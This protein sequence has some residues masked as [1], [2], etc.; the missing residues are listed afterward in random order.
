MYLDDRGLAWGP[1]ALSWS[2]RRDAL[3]HNFHRARKD[4]TN[5]GAAARTPA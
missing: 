5:R 3:R 2:R 1:A 4:S